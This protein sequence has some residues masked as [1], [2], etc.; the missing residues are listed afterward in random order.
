MGVECIVAGTTLV[1]GATD[2]VV[3]F[4]TADG[5]VAWS[6][7]VEGRA[8]GLAVASESLFVSTD[9]GHVYC[10]RPGQDG[11]ESTPPGTTIPEFETTELTPAG[12]ELKR[13]RL[14]GLRHQWVFQS[15]MQ[16]RARRRGLPN[17]AQYVEDRAGKRSAVVLGDVVLRQ[18][19]AV[20]ALE[21]DGST[22]SV[23]VSANHNELDLPGKQLTAEAWVRVD[24]AAPWGG[25][26][27]AVQDNGD[28]ER[29]WILGYT[30]AQFSFAV[31]GRE[32]PGRLTYLKAPEEY[33]PGAWY[34]VVGTYDG[35][36]Q[37]LYVNGRRVAEAKDQKGEINYPPQ[38]P[39]ELGAYHDKDEYFRMRGMLHEVLLYERALEAKDIAT[40]YE[41]KRRSFPVPIRLETGPYVRFVSPSEARVRWRTREASPTIIDFG[42][43]DSKSVS[44]TN[45]KREH[46]VTLKGLELDRVYSYVI[47]TSSSIVDGATDRFELDTHFNY[48]RPRLSP[49]SV[50]A[51]GDGRTAFYAD[52]ATRILSETGVEKGICVVY[53]CGDGRLAYELARRSDLRVVGFGEDAAQIAKGRARLRGAGYGTHVTLHHVTSLASLPVT[54]HFANLVVSQ[55][56]LDTGA[57]GGD[58]RELFRI[59]RPQGGAACL[60]WARDGRLFENGD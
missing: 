23:L 9:E 40:R 26:I 50:D 44:D 53:G 22:N 60:G 8:Y 30:N 35:R 15:G 11:R 6:F 54:G 28:Y 56:L 4:R 52:A 58:A 13:P 49:G 10:F 2:E 42:T 19:G 51:V 3:A 29:G 55:R 39:V 57:C 59:L 17:S 7:A 20:E 32:G 43:D 45:R 41:A 16:E 24:Q 14:A 18:V 34:H 27:G 21:L 47:R 25:F 37:R 33:E 31:A 46:T 1:V 38:S 5:Q 48:A 12:G 36:V